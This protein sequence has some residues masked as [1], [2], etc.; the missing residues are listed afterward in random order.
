MSFMSYRP[1][2]PVEVAAVELRRLESNGAR[3][4]QLGLT[5]LESAPRV[6]ADV[7]LPYEA[8][9]VLLLSWAQFCELHA[10]MGRQ[11]ELLRPLIAADMVVTK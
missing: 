8:N 6:S 5:V 11:I 1:R 3:V 7:G 10:S 9:S 2:P 4:V